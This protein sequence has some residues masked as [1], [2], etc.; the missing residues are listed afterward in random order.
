MALPDAAKPCLHV[1][2]PRN[3]ELHSSTFPLQ[4]SPTSGL[5]NRIKLVAGLFSLARKMQPTIIFVDE[6]D[7]F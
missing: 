2:L 3:R 5:E 7:T 4:Y 1:P 6:I